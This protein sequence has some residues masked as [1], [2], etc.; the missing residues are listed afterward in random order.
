[1]KAFSAGLVCLIMATLSS[2]AQGTFGL[3]NKA[4][5]DGIDAPVLDAKGSQLWGSEWRVE[6]YGGA[7]VDSLSPA[8]AIQS[9]GREII[10]LHAPGYFSSYHDLAVLG[11]PGGGQAWVQ[12]RV[13]SAALGATYEETAALG[14]GGYGESV[15][16]HL[17]AS[18]YDAHEMPA[19]LVG[20]QS[21][22][23]RPIVPEP[24]TV[25]LLG[26]GLAGLGWFC[27]KW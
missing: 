2:H 17:R 3:V 12:V 26:L 8:F 7:A 19:L 16:L 11:V 22:S 10:S 9:G 21:F 4:P 5:F 1:M 18:D 27:R 24:G 15:M 20:L 23:V 14:L 6:L 25:A 13:W